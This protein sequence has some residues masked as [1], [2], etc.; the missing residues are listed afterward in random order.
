MSRTIR[1]ISISLFLTVAFS[2][3]LK[4]GDAWGAT[5]YYVATTGNDG[6][7]GTSGSPWLTIGKAAATMV[8][9]DTTFVKVGTYL[10]TRVG[11][12]RYIPA[13]NPTNSGSAGN[14]IVF[15]NFGSDSV[16]I[17]YDPAETDGGPLIGSNEHAYIE[18]NGFIVQETVANYASDTGPVAIFGNAAGGTNTDHCSI[19]NC[20]IR[21]VRIVTTDNHCAVRIENANFAR[22][23][24][25]KIRGIT[26]G[27]FFF[28]DAGI[29]TY[30]MRNSVIDHNEISD[31]GAGMSIKGVAGNADYNDLDTLQFNLVYGCQYGIINLAASRLRIVQNVIRNGHSYTGDNTDVVGIQVWESCNGTTAGTCANGGTADDDI[32][33][34]TIYSCYYG[35]LMDGKSDRL[36][37][38]SR[39]WRNNIIVSTTYPL[40]TGPI[41]NGEDLLAQFAS[42]YND[43]F[44]WTQF[45]AFP[46]G[47]ATNYPPPLS[48]WVAAVSKD[49]HSISSDPLFVDATN[50]NFRLQTGSPAL[51]AG[52]DFGDL[53]GDANT[54]ELVNLGPYQSV[55]D[56]VGLVT[57]GGAVGGGGTPTQ[58][59]PPSF[60][61]V[62]PN[63]T[64]NEGDA[65]N[66]SAQAIDPDGGQTITVT[67]TGANLVTAGLSLNNGVAVAP[68]TSTGT[69][70]GVLNFTASTNSPYT[71]TWT[72]TDGAGGS[73]TATT[74]LTVLDVSAPG[75][76]PCTPF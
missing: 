19:K 35:V 3:A 26:D 28:N 9:G 10:Q 60:S 71:I 40:K 69:V 30:R 39:D 25:N 34:N 33:N 72:A 45:R 76:T 62:E 73:T 47:T 37:R 32:I 56:T 24:N 13:L 57:A 61:L 66:F 20:D 52:P 54:T 12:S 23:Y 63:R 36:T 55:A 65:V 41:Y 51:N 4:G 50:G 64:K 14:P 74:I 7:P 68:T 6:N 70:T 75:P 31:C 18:W 42:D 38:G 27:W 17:K 5:N 44:T 53:D 29:M 22:L 1:A 43:F 59:A 8:A 58:T 46:G 16:I 21:A 67:P 15:K 11:T 48:G 2:L 49:S